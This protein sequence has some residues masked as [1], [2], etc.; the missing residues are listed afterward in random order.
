MHWKCAITYLVILMLQIKNGSKLLFKTFPQWAFIS[1]GT[2]VHMYVIYISQFLPIQISVKSSAALIL[3]IYF[4]CIFGY[5]SRQIV[6]ED[7]ALLYE[8]WKESILPLI[9]YSPLKL[10]PNSF[11]VE[12][13]FAARSLVASRSFEIDDYHGFG[14]V[15]LA[16]L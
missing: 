11:G 12:Q 6:K 8:D 1:Y 5:I 16:D 13:Y 3:N 9:E 4:L 2:S 10:N 14:M 15:P 7:K